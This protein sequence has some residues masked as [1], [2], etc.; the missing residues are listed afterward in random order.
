[1]KDRD[2]PIGWL[3]VTNPCTVTFM[4]IIGW[5][6]C[7]PVFADDVSEKSN[8]S[9]DEISLHEGDDDLDASFLRKRVHVRVERLPLVDFATQL[10]KQV[11]VPV[12]IDRRAIADEGLLVN[13]ALTFS[14]EQPGLRQK[15]D[16]LIAAG[17]PIEDWDHKM[18]MRLDQVLDLLL[19]ELGMTWVVKGDM[20]HL[21]TIEAAQ[22]RHAINRSYSPSLFR[23]QKIE[24]ESLGFALSLEPGTL[25]DRRS[26]SQLTTVGQIL[27]IRESY[28][29]QRKLRSLLK[30]IANPVEKQSGTYN[31]EQAAGRQQ[32]EQIVDVDFLDTPL[33]EAIDILAYQSKGRLFLDKIAIE[34]SGGSIAQPI[35]FSLNGKSLRQTLDMLLPDLK[36]TVTFNAGELFITSATVA[37]RMRTSRVYDLRSIAPTQELRD[38]IVQAIID[39]SSELW[40]GTDGG[41]HV[42]MLENGVFVAVTNFE[43]HDEIE[44][45]VH[46][47]VQNKGRVGTTIG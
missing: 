10:S 15:V 32:L 29:N 16:E 42:K 46:L 24:D 3:Q 14:T 36:L 1:M 43:A 28:P 2:T 9:S 11:G 44:R 12:L 38:A 30:A 47:Y 22:E 13:E 6:A 8:D 45:L 27:T 37:W 40:Q 34:E 25:F 21:T 19:R 41:G 18:T 20:L 4:V 35:T 31:S 5:L 26:N 7:T 33:S 17:T 39:L 23:N